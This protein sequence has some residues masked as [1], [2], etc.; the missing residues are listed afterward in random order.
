MSYD[1]I[2]IGGGLGGLTAGAVLA[3]K[4]KRVLLLEQHYILGG[5]ATIF[6]RKDIHIEVGLHQ[7]DYGKYG[8]DI[9]RD[10]FDFLE[11]DKKIE[12]ISLPEIWGVV[13]KNKKYVV[14]QGIEEAKRIRPEREKC[15]PK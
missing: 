15:F 11:L 13:D 10:L 9:K 8:Y 7:M 12:L 3:K 2:I 1:V 4:Q 5:A 14:P 6:K